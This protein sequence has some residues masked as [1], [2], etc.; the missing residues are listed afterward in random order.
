LLA[1]QLAIAIEAVGELPEPTR[2]ALAEL[3][4]SAVH[5]PS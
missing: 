5:R 1:A 2:S 4:A 3:A